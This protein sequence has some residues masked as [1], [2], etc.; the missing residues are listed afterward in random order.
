MAVNP[1]CGCLREYGSSDNVTPDVFHNLQGVPSIDPSVRYTGGTGRTAGAGAGSDVSWGVVE[2]CH[3]QSVKSA[4][5]EE[6]LSSSGR[7]FSAIMPRAV[8]KQTLFLTHGEFDMM[9][10]EDLYQEQIRPLPVADRLQLIAHCRGPRQWCTFTKRRITELRGFFIA[11]RSG[12]MLTPSSISITCAA[13]GS[14]VRDAHRR[15][16]EGAARL[17]VDSAPFIYYIEEHP[18]YLA[19]VVGFSG[20]RYTAQIELVTSTITVSEVLI[21]P[22]RL[23]ADHLRDEYLDLFLNSAN[24]EIQSIDI[25]VA[26]RAAAL[27]AAHNIRLPDALQIGVSD[28]A[29]M[30]AALHSDE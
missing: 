6:T 12:K 21:H 22:L 28:G 14:S 2:M 5:D 15:C 19:H 7:P 4:P 16:A 13:N 3:E 18:T 20:G 30:P 10:V 24:L 17:G 1:A 29:A 23:G 11:R 26:Q 8:V 27:R 9:L 25:D